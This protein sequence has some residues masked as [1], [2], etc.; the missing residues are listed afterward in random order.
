MRVPL[1]DLSAQY[2]TI[3]PAIDAA[4]GSMESLGCLDR[5]RELLEETRE[6][7]KQNG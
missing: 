6:P 1:V 7:S 2:S 3:K 4:L 5:I